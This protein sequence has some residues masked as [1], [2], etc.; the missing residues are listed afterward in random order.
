MEV[1]QIE[2]TLAWL[3]DELDRMA[4]SAEQLKGRYIDARN[5]LA[6]KHAKGYRFPALAPRI[7]QTK[8]GGVSVYWERFEVRKEGQPPRGK[9]IRSHRTRGYRKDTL[10][11]H[12]RSF[13]AELVWDTECTFEQLRQRSRLLSTARDALLKLRDLE[14]THE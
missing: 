4:E 10:V 2:G 9:H 3:N 6:D 14:N 8:N 12:S 7:R 11:R 13:D 5:A 1:K